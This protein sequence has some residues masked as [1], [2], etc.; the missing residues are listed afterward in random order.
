VF[1]SSSYLVLRHV[2]NFYFI[3]FFTFL[4]FLFFIPLAFV[5]TTEYKAFSLQMCWQCI[6]SLTITQTLINS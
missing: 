1:R 6:W 3:T 4:T 5:S 2:Y